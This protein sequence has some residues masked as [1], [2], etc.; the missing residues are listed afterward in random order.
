[1]RCTKTMTAV[2]LYS[3]RRISTI[4]QLNE[5]RKGSRRGSVESAPLS[6]V[7]QFV[8]GKRFWVSFCCA[9]TAFVIK[10]LNNKKG[11]LV[12]GKNE[13]ERES[14][15]WN[16]NILDSIFAS[17]SWQA[18]YKPLFSWVAT[19]VY[20]AYYKVRLI[21]LNNL[22]SIHN[23]ISLAS[24][25]DGNIIVNGDKVIQYWFGQPPNIQQKNLW[26]VSDLKRRDAA[27]RYI[28]MHFSSHVVELCGSKRLR[29]EWCQ[30]RD[31][32][33][34]SIIVLDQFTRHIHRFQEA[35]ATNMAMTLPPLDVSDNLAHELAKS[36]QV[37]YET[38]ISSG[39]VPL[40]MYIFSLMPYRH[41]GATEKELESVMERIDLAEKR[42]LKDN[43]ALLKRFRS[44]TA[45]RLNVLYDETRRQGHLNVEHVENCNKESSCP[46]ADG[47]EEGTGPIPDEAILEFF[48]FQADMQPLQDHQLVTAIRQFLDEQDVPSL[49]GRRERFF[50]KNEVIKEPSS[51]RG[52]HNC[53]G[54]DKASSCALI[55]SLSGGVDSMAIA[56]V[57][58]HISNP[59]S[60]LY[61]HDFH[62]FAAH[63]DYANRP[64]SGAEAAYIERFCR[65]WNIYYKC[66]RIEEVTRGITNR[67]EYESISRT[68][69]Y[70]LYKELISR[71]IP[72]AICE[73][74]KG[75]NANVVGVMLGHHRG[76]LRENVLSNSCKGCG[77]LDLSGMTKVSSIEGVTVLRPL[78]SLEKDVIFDYAHKVGVPYFKDTTPH[79]STRGKLR[80]HLLP[81]LTD[82][83]GE[84]CFAN[85]S[86]LATE[87]D[88]ARELVISTVVTP[89][90][91]QVKR[92]PMGLTF[93]T[94]P[95]KNSSSFFWKFILRDLM[96]SAGRG[97]FSDKSVLSFLGR[98]QV[99][100]IPKSGWLQCR[101]DYA[102][103]LQESGKVFVFHPDSFPWSKGNQYKIEGR[104]LNFPRETRTKVGPWVIEAQIVDA[105]DD[106]TA[107]AM[108]SQKAINSMEYLM[109][110][111]I[112]Y[113][114]K[115]PKQLA[116]NEAFQSL[117]FCE[118]FTK[119]NR[120]AAWTSTDIKVQAILPLLVASPRAFLVSA[121]NTSFDS[122]NVIRITMKLS[123]S[124]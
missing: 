17:P 104:G 55:V 119:R 62:V 64:E 42:Y 66:R 15:V 85:L 18:R 57:L 49:H 1:M 23:S 89:F 8:P 86:H 3:P 33:L 28:A 98:I 102:V 79:W 20:K 76:D 45:R 31:G 109:Q 81:L 22:S 110:G 54:Q 113:H 32:H 43:E 115:L 61:S 12:E 7:S 60:P 21:S 25:S 24:N 70:D 84:G 121:E 14:I 91:D 40:P 5:I 13:N 77:P 122:H 65:Q 78:L 93:E 96:H 75:M 72:D 26:M 52:G 92:Y 48:P 39:Q 106:K 73:D 11:C 53:K 124:T 105:E 71:D 37:K 58:S 35:N 63:I 9:A 111:S 118:M 90:L 87:S 69:R 2:S 117:I 47:V 68:M 95:W 83:Y 59:D 16:R 29:D 34:A 123:H 4:Q 108:L 50:Q 112:A 120:P 88:A 36:F 6:F 101:K 100:G 82:V 67:D 99:E 56:S 10:A 51:K 97:M 114:L 19:F 74:S 38:H 46:K 30:T 80:N 27:D 116:V 41:N 103:Y 94:A 107:E 44:A